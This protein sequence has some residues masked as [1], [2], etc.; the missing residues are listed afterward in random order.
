V[1]S[2]LGV[3]IVAVVIGEGGSG[4]AL[5]LGVAN[6]VH[7]MQY[8]IYSVISPEG[9]A[10]ILMKDAAN[11]PIAAEALK[12]T[13]PHALALGVID[14]IIPEPEGGAHRSLADTARNIKATITRDLE[15]LCQMPPDGLKEQRMQ[16][17]MQLGSVGDGREIIGS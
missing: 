15:Q 4:G 1:M 10:S 6:R 7:M 11:A 5:A 12:L 17:F 9:C 2:R 14:S 13:A 16:K 8:S 3:P